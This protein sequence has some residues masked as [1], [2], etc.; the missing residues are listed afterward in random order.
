MKK[1]SSIVSFIAICLVFLLLIGINGNNYISIVQTVAYKLDNFDVETKNTISSI[2]RDNFTYHSEFID[3][4]GLSKKAFGE[5]I[6]GNYEYVKDESG[7]MQHVGPNT[8]DRSNYITSIKNLMAILNGRNIPCVNV[9][10]PDRGESFSVSEQFYYNGKKDPNAEDEIIG[11]GVDEFNV[12]EKVIDYGLI[13]HDDFFFHTDVHLTTEA[14][15]LMAKRLTE[16]LTDKYSISFPNSDTVYDSEMYDWQD[17]VFCGNFCGSTGKLFAGVDNFQTFVPKFET[18]MMLTFPD[19]NI[20]QGLFSDVMTNQYV[21]ENSYWVT[22]YGQ[23]PTLYYTYDN[24][25][26]QNAPRLLVLCDS[27]F[28]RSNTFLALNSSHLTILDPR[29]INGNEYIIDCLLD[30]DYDAIIICHTDYFNNNLFLSNAYLPENILPCSEIS[31]KGMWLDNV[32]AINLNSG[33]YTQ[34]EIFGSF[35]QNSQ[36]VFFNG[37]AADFNFNMPL[38]ALYIRVGEK[39]VK[40]Q[41][42]LERTSVSEHFQNENLKMTGFNVTI[43]KSYLD[44]VDTIEFIQVG[45]DGSYRFEAVEYKLYGHFDSNSSLTDISIP[46]TILPHQQTSYN[47]M[48]LDTVDGSD[49]N[50]IG[51]SQGEIPIQLLNNSGTVSLVG[52]AA[53]FTVNQPLSALYLKVGDNTIKCQYGIERT[54]VSDA[55]QNPDLEMTGFEISIPAEYLKGINEIEFIQVGNDGT[56]SFEPIVYKLITLPE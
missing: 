31:Y 51:I 13:S 40:C 1:N 5:K 22:N 20:R 44:G 8:A 32:N 35:Y 43:P 15:L 56:Y 42:G 2:L 18:E 54:S 52:W 9:K 6:I 41:Y 27:M 10:L 3:A 50:N 21:E 26:Y 46:N 29:Y 14:E 19:G 38:S 53:D 24:L 34:G 30:Y 25:K 28:M 55:F 49:I 36:T 33:E 17:H 7:I 16:Y 45:T 12:Q 37:W 11:Y 39:T 4:Y 48:W 23:W 47:G